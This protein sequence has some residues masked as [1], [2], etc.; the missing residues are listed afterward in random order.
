MKQD[1]KQI[2]VTGDTGYIGSHTCIELLNENYSVVAVDN[3][4]D[5][6]LKLFKSMEELSCKGGRC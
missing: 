5:R 3:L 6:E 1:N 4:A 2:L